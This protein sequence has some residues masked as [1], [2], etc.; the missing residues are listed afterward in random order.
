MTADPALDEEFARWRNAGQEPRF[1]LRDDDAGEPGPALDRLIALCEKFEVPLLLAVVPERAGPALGER[2][3]DV[4]LVRPCVHG[5]AHRDNARE[6]E[7][8]IELGGRMATADI[9]DGLRAS[10]EKLEG[11]FGA[12]LSG[13]LVP[14]WNRIAPDIAARAHECGFTALSTWSWE[15]RGTLLPEIN[16]HVD[17]MDWTTRQGRPP[18]WIRGEL[19]RRLS[20]ARARGGAP[21]GILSHHLDHDDRAW[22]T[23]EGLLRHLTVERGFAFHHADDL[24]AGMQPRP[25]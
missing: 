15:P 24:A 5:I 16:T 17:L 11:L 14:P 18:E 6:G 12:R 20:Q 2:L 7:R 3:R 4:R 13:I 25:Q 1:W 23:L 22:R 19:L 8:K 21:I 9:L 10:R